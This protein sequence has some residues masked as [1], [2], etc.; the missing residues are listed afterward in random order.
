MT[1]ATELEAGDANMVEVPVM[2]G[3]EGVVDVSVGGGVG[4]T[5]GVDEVLV[6]V[7][8][9]SIVDELKMEEDERVLDVLNSVVL[10]AGTEELEP[11]RMVRGSIVIPPLGVALA[12]VLDAG[13]FT[14]EVTDGDG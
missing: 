5:T 12:E 3:V 8:L 7:E 10:E 14:L 9:D 13:S 1:A 2:I 4:T 11:V 6:M